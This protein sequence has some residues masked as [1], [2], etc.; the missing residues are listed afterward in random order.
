VSGLPA[1]ATEKARRRSVWPLLLAV[2]SGAL[3]GLCFGR[4]AAMV[5]PWVALAPLVL[6]LR[7]PRAFV[8]GLAH[9]TTAWLV[10]IPW[11]VPTLEVYGR[12]GR[13]LAW[14]LLLL[15][16]LYLGL[17]HGLFAAVGGRLRR[18]WP[19]SAWGDAWALATLPALWVALEWL[20]AHLFGGFPWNLAAYT[21]T[22][23]PG[24]LPLSAWVGAYGVSYLVLWATTGLA[25][26][27]ERR[28]AT[29]AFLGLALPFLLL[30]VAGRWAAAETP[31]GPGQPV[32]L[33]QPN[34]PNLVAWDAAA[35][36]ENYRRVL[37]QSRAACDEPGALLVWP[38]S[39]AWPFS[40]ERD[41]FLLE[42]A[43]ALARAGCSVLLNSSHEEGGKT[44]NSA[45]LVDAEGPPQRYDKRHL[46]PWGE[47]V[48]LGEVLPFVGK[49]ARAAGDFTPAEELRL[50]AW[51]SERLG[52]AICFEV[53]FPEE[54]AALARAGATIL[55]TITNDAWYGDTA[56]PWQ[57]FRAARFRAAENRRPL[58][59]AA[60]TGVSALVAADGKAVDWL[61]P[62][63]EGILSGR[64]V[65]RRDL[66]PYSRRPWLV[67]A[68]C[69]LVALVALAWSGGPRD[70]RAARSTR[71]LPPS[72][73]TPSPSGRGSG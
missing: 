7:Q 52:P 21:W 23:F 55:V 34:I 63:A 28:T 50:L 67:P 5:L 51:R 48:P 65:G 44:Y 66:S 42:D 10:S 32:R 27:I 71:P 62:F 17:F 30:A 46:V 43:R 19:A 14:A 36:Q 41:A 64:V 70:R 73:G 47:Y 1:A 60:I 3:W 31:R 45:Y 40:L 18:R 2:A 15:L 20:R 6:L 72:E 38:E 4:R 13:G 11:I 22:E 25:V 8:L 58:L 61:G 29:P 24:A 33:L 54:T 49:L 12:V 56:A 57:H 35:V 68:A 9:G 69:A 59:R 26:A 37:A 39:A 53:I 16:T